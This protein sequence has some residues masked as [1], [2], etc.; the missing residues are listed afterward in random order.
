MPLPTATELIDTAVAFVD[1]V[2]VTNILAVEDDLL[3]AFEGGPG[4][5]FLPGNQ[6]AD[7]LGF[8]RSGWIE[9]SIPLYLPTPVA[10]THAAATL[11]MWRSA[12]REVQAFIS[13]RH[14]Q[15]GLADDDSGAIF[16][17]PLSALLASVD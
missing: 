13:V 8:V 7:S 4:S 12:A 11:E 1:H 14:G 10:R 6:R 3:V 15:I 5:W 16:S 2:I 9:A 17:A